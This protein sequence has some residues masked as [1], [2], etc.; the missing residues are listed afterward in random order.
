MKGEQEMDKENYTPPVIS[1]LS[2]TEYLHA[3][4]LIESKT[5][6]ST[7]KYAYAMEAGQLICS[8]PCKSKLEFQ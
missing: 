6:Y 4:R 1:P 8:M 5:T 7:E 2:C 3:R